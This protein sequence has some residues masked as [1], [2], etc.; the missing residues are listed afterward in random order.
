MKA[1]ILGQVL[2]KIYLQ[3]IR[4]DESA[5]Y[6]AGARGWSTYEGNNFFTA[7]M[8]YCPMKPE[9]AD[10]ALQIMNNEMVEAT[11][12]IDPTTLNEIKELAVKDLTT[13]FKENGYWLN[14]IHNY[15]F[16]GADGHTG[17]LDIIAAQTPESIAAFAKQLLNT[18]N[19]IEVV[20]LPEE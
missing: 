17:I 10:I 7:V 16:T 11:K 19:K 3:K 6:S 20:M 14:Q 4:E 8:G 13:N 1:N 5:A 12:N 15:L 18:G 9:K 2:G